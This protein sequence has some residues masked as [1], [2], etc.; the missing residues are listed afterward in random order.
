LSSLVVQA[1]KD[2]SDLRVRIDQETS[3]EIPPDP[4]SDRP[5]TARTRG[6]W[7]STALLALLLA[8]TSWAVASWV[9]AWLV[10]PYLILMALLLSPST[11]RH[12]GEPG[13]EGSDASDPTLPARSVEGF[14]DFDS[15][16]DASDSSETPEDGSEQ[17]ATSKSSKTRRG[18]GRV[19]KAKA[20]PEP[21]EATWVQVAPGKFVRVEAADESTG[22]AGPHSQVGIPVEVPTTPQRLEFEEGDDFKQTESQAEN[23]EP[24][25][26][27]SNAQ[28][29]A[30]L[31]EPSPL[32]G[33]IEDARETFD[34]V[35]GPE[36]DPTGDVESVP[37]TAS[38]RDETARS[39]ETFE[40]ASATAGN[41]PRAEGSFESDETTTADTSLEE[42]VEDLAR[43]ELS[44]PLAFA[45]APS[46]EIDEWGAILEGTDPTE[47]P[48]DE[49]DLDDAGPNMV[50]P[51][52]L[53]SSEGA[54]LSATEPL[55]GPSAGPACWPWRL[56]PGPRSRVGH[57]LSR[58]IG[59]TSPPR[60]TVRS[61]EGARRPLDPRRLERRGVARP[62]QVNRTF[63]PRSPPAA[64]V[65]REGRGASKGKGVQPLSVF[66]GLVC[67][68]NPRFY[69]EP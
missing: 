21:T 44:S 4:S 8:G 35:E 20:V 30:L 67:A 9:A 51:L 25:G 18:K 19:K 1:S 65:G 41:A 24:Q 42:A 32:E 63:P 6:K 11:G 23:E 2:R 27:E 54:D 33:P 56:A 52:E 13:S 12:Q 17:A 57:A 14:G 10:L 28:P 53:E 22:Q 68:L 38:D 66:T 50:A 37:W 62:R 29:E 26:S 58:S 49:T 55:A 59:R 36:S 40:K 5:T 39:P 16:S 7:T 3:P 69:G 15:P 43:V 47:T 48:V 45:D 64:H 31:E 60:R 34:S 61:R 46:E